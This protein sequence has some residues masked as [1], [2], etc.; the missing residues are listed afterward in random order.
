MY[1]NCFH[2][3]RNLTNFEF[4]SW[5]KTLRHKRVRVSKIQ[6][7]ASG[8]KKAWEKNKQTLTCGRVEVSLFNYPADVD[9]L[10]TCKKIARSQLKKVQMV[11][12][13]VEDV[14]KNLDTVIQFP[15]VVGDND[16]PLT[17]SDKRELAILS[18]M[19]GLW[20][21]K[22]KQYLKQDLVLESSCDEEST[23]RLLSVFQADQKEELLTWY[24]GKRFCKKETRFCYRT[25]DS[26]GGKIVRKKALAPNPNGSYP[27]AEDAI[28]RRLKF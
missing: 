26:K 17:H 15:E 22:F 8:L 19:C 9:V 2:A 28:D 11:K 13:F 23:P 1:P 12:V 14:I 3:V 21:Y 27:S 25:W 18:N 4:N 16:T 10:H 24:V 7:L 5:P 20:D 6:S